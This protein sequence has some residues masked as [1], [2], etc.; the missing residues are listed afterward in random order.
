MVADKLLLRRVRRVV[1]V[2]LVVRVPLP[3]VAQA[4]LVRPLLQPPEE[5]A[6]S[7][8][9]TLLLRLRC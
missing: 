4:R 1:P 7:S 8:A 2:W 9:V 3:T 6:R 5:A